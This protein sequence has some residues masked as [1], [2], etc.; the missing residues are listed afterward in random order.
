MADLQKRLAA[1]VMGCGIDR[2]RFDPAKLKE[3]RDAIT[4]QD[5]R[6]LVQ[7]RAITK[8]PVLGRSGYQASIR[9]IRRQKGRRQGPGS[10]E[11]A[12][13]ARRGKKSL[14]INTIRSQRKYLKLL[15]GNQSIT[16]DTFKK[17]YVLAKGGLFRSRGHI[18]L[19]LEEHRLLNNETHKETKRTVS[20]KEKGRAH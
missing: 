16:N 11:G 4:K 1:E 14:W 3:I 6:R 2:V 9:K 10:R 13:G 7:Q 20:E 15:K 19:Y 5:I 18:R 12:K 17:I 8:K